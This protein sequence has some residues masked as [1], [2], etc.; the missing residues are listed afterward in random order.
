MNPDSPTPDSPPAP[1]TSAQT[2]PVGD[3]YARS[4]MELAQQEQ[5][6]DSV[7]QEVAGIGSLV[8]E[9]HDFRRLIGNPILGRQQREQMLQ[10]LFEGRV[11]DLTYRFLQVLNRK[12][13][14]DA[15]PQIT[16][17]FDALLAEHRNELTVLAYV[18]HRLAPDAA[19]RVAQGLSASLGKSVTLHQHVDPALIGGMKLRIGDRMLDASVATQLRNLEQQLIAAGRDRA[20]AQAAADLDPVTA[21]AAD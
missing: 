21:A 4:L 1:R 9:D 19:D 5:Q 12:D 7:A 17:A 10:R 11:S 6:L 13:R 2:S 8:R 14:L 18:P 16:A 3:V 15:L 20:R